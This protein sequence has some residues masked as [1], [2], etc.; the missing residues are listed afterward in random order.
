MIFSVE[1]SERAKKELR[2][3]PQ[4]VALKV[5]DWVEDVEERGLEEVRKISGYHDEPCKGVMRGLR[6]IRLTL[7]YRAYYSIQRTRVEFVRIERI[8]K[9]EY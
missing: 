5:Q 4:H 7:A 1:L 3:V 9:H 8:D 6:S 2:K